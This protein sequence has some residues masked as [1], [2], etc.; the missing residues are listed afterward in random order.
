MQSN[1][2]DLLANKIY[3]GRHAETGYKFCIFETDRLHLPSPVQF[4]LPLP[5]P[6]QF[7]PPLSSPVQFQLP[8]SSPVQFQPPLPSSVL[9]FP[10]SS[11]AL[12]KGGQLSP[13]Q[14]DL[15]TEADERCATGTSR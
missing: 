4:Q 6:V 5:S 13:P 10:L 11:A 9:G 3:R 14:P 8:L 1:F 15:L 2:A 7:Q 12:A